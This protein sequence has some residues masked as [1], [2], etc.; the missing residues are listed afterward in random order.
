MA[1]APAGG[2]LEFTN[3]TN[4]SEAWI[5]ATTTPRLADLNTK[6]S[7][8]FESF[9]L[10]ACAF[11]NKH[12]KRYWNK[13]QADDIFLGAKLF[14]G[15]YNEFALTNKPVETI[16]TI[17][18][19]VADTFTEVDQTYLQLDKSASIIRITPTIN[20]INAVSLP[21]GL[22]NNN[23]NLWV[24]YTSGYESADVPFDVKLATALYVDYLYSMD[25]MDG[26]VDSFSTQTYSQKSG[27]KESPKIERVMS[28]LAPYIRRRFVA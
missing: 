13:Q 27:T 11:V 10:A 26:G 20:I 8:T 17:W 3:P 9:V 15:T 6:Y 22:Y 2:A 16:D 7:S 25:S 4:L 18:V 21:T 1:L 12:T 28:M 19:Q 14:Y 5:S 23:S 24:R